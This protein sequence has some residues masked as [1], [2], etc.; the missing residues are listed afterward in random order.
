[1]DFIFV[2]ISCDRTSAQQESSTTHKSRK[3]EKKVLDTEALS[4]GEFALVE[5]EDEEDEQSYSPYKAQH[6]LQFSAKAFA[7]AQWAHKEAF[8]P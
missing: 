1:L 3:K 5:K 4:R 8:Q 7:V 6:V 2:F